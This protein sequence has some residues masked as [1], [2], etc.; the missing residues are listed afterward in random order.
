M[1]AVGGIDCNKGR[2]PLNFFV[3]VIASHFLTKTTLALSKL[4][5]C[6]IKDEVHFL[7]K[8]GIMLS[9]CLRKAIKTSQ[10]LGSLLQVLL[11]HKIN[12]YFR[13]HNYR[14]I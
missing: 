5:T 7:K 8:K 6:Y 12:I 9:Q 13:G 4:M 1:Y 10:N 14:E 11:F 3:N 2:G